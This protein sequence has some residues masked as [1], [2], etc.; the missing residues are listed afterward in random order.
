MR[1]FGGTLL[2]FRGSRYWTAAGEAKREAVNRWI[3]SSRAFDGVIDFAASV[4]DPTDPEMISPRYDSG[5]RLHLD[6]AGYR[7]MAGAV[8]LTLL[9]GG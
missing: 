7:A 1:I 8:D 4:A 9:L 2:P 6:N 3:H 5:D